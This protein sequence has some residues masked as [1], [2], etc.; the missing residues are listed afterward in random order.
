MMANQLKRRDKTLPARVRVTSIWISPDT[1][2]EQTG[3]QFL[4]IATAH[5]QFLLEFTDG[6]W[7]KVPSPREVGD[8][9]VRYS[10]SPFVRGK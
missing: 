7:V 8:W 10:E 5:A 1:V 4:S 6:P 9:L 3:E 2:A